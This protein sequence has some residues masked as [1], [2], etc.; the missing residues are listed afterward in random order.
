[1]AV[2]IFSRLPEAV[3]KGILSDLRDGWGKWTEMIGRSQL[4]ELR[5]EKYLEILRER[6]QR[7]FGAQGAAS[8]A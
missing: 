3:V 2:R 6:H 7:L 5:Q 8:P 1:M 4:S